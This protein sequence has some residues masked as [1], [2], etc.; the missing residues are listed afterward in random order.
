MEEAWNSLREAIQY[1]HDNTQE[2]DLYNYTTE[3]LDY[4]NALE[5]PYGLQ[6]VKCDATACKYN[7]DKVCTK[8]DKNTIVI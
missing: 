3:L 2:Q 5:E 6:E 8:Q 4:M 1:V 7:V